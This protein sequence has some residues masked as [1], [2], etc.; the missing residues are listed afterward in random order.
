MRHLG[1]VVG[2]VLNS[3]FNPSLSTIPQ[4]LL[5]LPLLPAMAVWK[6]APVSQSEEAA[7]GLPET[8]QQSERGG[9]GHYHISDDDIALKKRMPLCIGL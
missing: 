8:V 3:P 1:V 6:Y 2:A 7:S 4:V 9:G 5:V